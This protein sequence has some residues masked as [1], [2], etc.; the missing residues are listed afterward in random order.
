[1]SRYVFVFF[2]AIRIFTCCQ[3]Y[4][5]KHPATLHL[6]LYKTDPTVKESVNAFITTQINNVKSG[7]R[8]AVSEVSLRP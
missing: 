8:K 5:L 2:S 3:T 1:M 6:E 7:F 4:I